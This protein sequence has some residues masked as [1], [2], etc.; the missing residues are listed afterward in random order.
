[1]RLSIIPIIDVF[2]RRS[3]TSAGLRPETIA[4]NSET[5]IHCWLPNTL[6]LPSPKN[7]DP[8]V[9]KPFLLLL[10]GFGPVST[11]Q[12]RFQVRVL[13][14]HFD[15]IVPD[16]VF[17]G[18]STTTSPE[19][20]EEFQAA[21]MMALLKALGISGERIA[22]VLGTSYGGFVAYHLARMLGDGWMGK[23]VIASS[24]VGKNEEDDR[25]MVERVGGIENVS[26]IML[27]RTTVALRKL[28]KLSIRRPPRFLPEFIL[29]DVLQN[30]YTDNLERKMELIKGVTLGNKDL[31]QLTPLQQDVLIVWGDQDNIFPVNKAFELKKKLG[32]KA[33]LEIL[34]N[35]GHVPQIEDPDL[36]NKVL[37]GFLLGAPNSSV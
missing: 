16:L 26:E 4:V 33:K 35:T 3:F 23:V 27:P 15:L 13:S 25:A 29:R 28:L 21:A 31:F 19:R 12:W 30:L 37:L 2:A 36:F 11:W 20:S 8:R 10:H 14:R 6:S 24:D 5:T 22:G 9:S 17:F 34:K 7:P 18:E 32:E 1:M